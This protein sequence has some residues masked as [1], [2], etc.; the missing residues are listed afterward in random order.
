MVR[1][2]RPHRPGK[3]RRD[4]DGRSGAWGQSAGGHGP[5]ASPV[6]LVPPPP[7]ARGAD[8]GGVVV[9][10]Q[11]RGELRQ[12]EQEAVVVTFHEGYSDLDDD[13][14]YCFDLGRSHPAD[15]A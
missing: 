5:R 9:L 10:R 7:P 4:P 12:G 3:V 6:E 15:G 13:I 8:A 2:L 1:Y 11:L 14:E